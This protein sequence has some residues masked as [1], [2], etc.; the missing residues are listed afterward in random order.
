MSWPLGIGVY[1]IIWWTML[2]ASLPFG[3]RSQ[4]EAGEIVPGSEPGAPVRPRL[5]RKLLV[6]TAVSA[7]I[8]VLVDVAYIVFYLKP[9]PG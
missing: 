4:H 8:W 6:N 2:T 7:V 3:V 1:F 5:G 9:H